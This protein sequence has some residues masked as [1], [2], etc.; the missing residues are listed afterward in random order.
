MDRSFV[1]RND[2][3][4]NNNCKSKRRGWKAQAGR[5][6]ENTRCRTAQ[7]SLR[8]RIASKQALRQACP[9]N[10]HERAPGDHA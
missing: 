10:R 1:S 2:D 6:M 5:A 4:F 9:L 7:G 8:Y 3:L